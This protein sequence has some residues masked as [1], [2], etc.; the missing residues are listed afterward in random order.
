MGPGIAFKGW[1]TTSI[2]GAGAT[3]SAAC[4]GADVCD[5]ILSN[6]TKV[7]KAKFEKI[8]TLKVSISQGSTGAG[9]SLSVTVSNQGCSS[10]TCTYPGI[11]AGQSL[12][13]TATPN[14][15]SYLDAWANVPSGMA[16]DKST[17]KCAVSSMSADM[18]VTAIFKK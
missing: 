16:C 5:F 9:G 13:I 12:T 15:G 8:W 10:G 7:V 2:L 14:G 4:S 1:E 18:S 17:R 3:A 6:E 11:N